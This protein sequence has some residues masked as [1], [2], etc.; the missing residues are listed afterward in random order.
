M[1]M[2]TL[3]VF[4]RNVEEKKFGVLYFVNRAILNHQ[5]KQWRW[6]LQNV[7][8]KCDSR[9][10][11][12]HFVFY[13]FCAYTSTFVTNREG[14]CVSKVFVLIVFVGTEE[15]HQS[16]TSNSQIQLSHKTYFCYTY[17]NIIYSSRN[18]DCSVPRERFISRFIQGAPNFNNFLSYNM[19]HNARQE[20]VWYGKECHSLGL[21]CCSLSRPGHV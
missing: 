17:P 12:R 19:Y 8:R 7:L 14:T 21:K 10:L 18:L 13:I 3:N 5:N 15:E 11:L 20:L 9:R 4:L 2:T 1:S 6:I 16:F